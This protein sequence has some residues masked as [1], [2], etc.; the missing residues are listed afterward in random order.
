MAVYTKF[1][2]NFVP[3]QWRIQ[4]WAATPPIDQNLGLVM[5]VCQTR[6]QIFTHISLKSSIFGPL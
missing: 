3:Y 4:L 5:A 2:S 1:S 6:G